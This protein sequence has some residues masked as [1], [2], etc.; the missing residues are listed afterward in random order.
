MTSFHWPTAALSSEEKWKRAASISWIEPGF[1]Q[2]ISAILKNLK[3]SL[4]DKKTKSRATCPATLNKRVL[5]SFWIPCA[6]H[7]TIKQ[8][9]HLL[10]T[11]S[12]SELPS[13]STDRVGIDLPSG[14]SIYSLLV[15]RESRDGVFQKL[16]SATIDLQLNPDPTFFHQICDCQ[17]YQTEG[18]HAY[19]HIIFPCDSTL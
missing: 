17:M 5:A 7:F 3:D 19:I 6:D 13:A 1:N 4:V 8:P 9:V 11:R 10:Y 18:M 15:S 2:Y 16:Y 14:F 12:H